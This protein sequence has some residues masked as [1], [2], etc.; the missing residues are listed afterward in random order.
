MVEMTLGP[1]GVVVVVETNPDVRHTADSMKADVDAFRELTQGV[2]LP[3]LWD[4]RSMSR[5]TPDAW[6]EFLEDVAG[7]LTALAMIVDEGSR[8]VTGS[9]SWAMNSF[10]FPA[11]VFESYAEA[12]DWLR[13]FVPPGFGGGE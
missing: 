12:L 7:A 10:L 1:D 8:N 9:F 5:P 13:Q 11:Q 3:V 4:V 6:R 2:P